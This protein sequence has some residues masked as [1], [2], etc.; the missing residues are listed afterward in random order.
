MSNLRGAF[1]YLAPLGIPLR[2]LDDLWVGNLTNSPYQEEF[3]QWVI[4][5]RLEKGLLARKKLLPIIGVM[6]NYAEY[7]PGLN[8]SDQDLLIP[9][10]NLTDPFKL[11]Q[12][13][14]IKYVVVFERS[15]PLDYYFPIVQQPV[16]LVNCPIEQYM[17]DSVTCP[18]KPLAGYLSYLI[19]RHYNPKH[20]IHIK[21][22]EGKK[23]E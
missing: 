1:K 6:G 20:P 10:P 23:N 13:Y 16:I 12:K 2:T 7:L 11:V 18:I 8:E 9:S 19:L 17:Y 21:V 3:N 22:S 15:E 14:R 5:K 4:D